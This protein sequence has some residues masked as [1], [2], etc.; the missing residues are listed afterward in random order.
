[1]GELGRSQQTAPHGDGRADRGA[2]LLHIF[3]AD[4]HRVPVRGARRAIEH[5]HEVTPSHRDRQRACSNG[6]YR[7]LLPYEMMLN[8]PPVTE[9]RAGSNMRSACFVLLR[10]RMAKARFADSMSNGSGCRQPIDKS[11]ARLSMN[12]RL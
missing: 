5:G 12:A 9:V 11:T 3:G 6:H 7:P 4:E 10:F 8:R 1:M 2:D